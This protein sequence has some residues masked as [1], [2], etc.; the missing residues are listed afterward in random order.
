MKNV[1][2][3]FGGQSVE[4][5]IS[6]ITGLG[7]LNNASKEYNLVGLYI[8]KNN[9]WWTGEN[10][11]NIS[12]FQPFNIKR[13]KKCCALP[14][15]KLL[16][17]NK[18]GKRVIEI[19][20]VVNCLHG[21]NGEDGAMAGLLQIYGFAHTSTGVLGAAICMDKTITKQ[22]LA[23]NKIK[24]VDYIN[25]KKND[26]TLNTKTLLKQVE[27]KIGFPCI[28]KPN[29]LGS[30][31]GVNV[32][33]NAQDLCKCLDIAFS[34]DD[35]V[36]IEKY[37]QN[38]RELNIAALYDE[39]NI[40]VSNVEE[41]CLD[42]KLYEFNDKYKNKNTKRIVPADIEEDLQQDIINQAVKAYKLLKC[43]GVVRFDFLYVLGA[44]YLNE[45]N[46]VPGSLAGYLF[47]K[48]KIK[49]NTLITKLIEEGVTNFNKT[50]Q[51]KYDF[52]SGVLQSLTQNSF[53]MIK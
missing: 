18:F 40:K 44:L 31:I 29:S 21:H 27:R 52:E 20:C 42:S 1:L 33:T 25:I 38:A 8:D 51:L 19:Y 23:Y 34:F 46:T 43:K 22:V 4:H 26:Y 16:I 11:K 15:S 2:V 3:V 48:P 9:N 50:K 5:D 37:L 7:V 14:D 49:Y 53:K 35:E 39:N 24:V 10:L 6:V 36:L 41:V 47:K 12:S 17:L 13:L 28:V 32:V 45:V 30:S